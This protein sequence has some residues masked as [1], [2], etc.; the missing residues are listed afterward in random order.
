MVM[1]QMSPG[2]CPLPEQYIYNICHNEVLNFGILLTFFEHVVFVFYY[3]NY[4]LSL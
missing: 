1:G 3:E 2:A 4:P